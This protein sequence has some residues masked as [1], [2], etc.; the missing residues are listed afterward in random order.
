MVFRAPLCACASLLQRALALPARIPSARGLG[1][2]STR[3]LHWAL[4]LPAR[5]Q[6][7][8]GSMRRPARAL[9]WALARPAWPAQALQKLLASGALLAM[10][11]ANSVISTACTAAANPGTP[12]PRVEARSASLLAVGIVRGDRMAIHLSRLADN[13]PVRDAVLTVVLRGVVH[14][15]VAEADGSYTLQAKDLT[16]PG[17]AAVVFQVADGDA[18]DQLKGALEV[19]AA[20]AGLSDKNSARQLGWWVL[21][22]AVCV[23]FLMLLSRRRKAA[24]RE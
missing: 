7:A 22:F 2:P 16:L 6:S 4:A 13:A 3:A 9:N 12:P 24:A 5:T 15:T 21:N 20:G 17:A 23:G 19:P 1:G 8:A 10:V 11:G 18:H 14:P